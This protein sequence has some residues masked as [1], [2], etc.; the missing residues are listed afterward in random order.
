[1]DCSKVIFN[2]LGCVNCD[3]VLWIA[4]DVVEGWKL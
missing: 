2:V 3:K 1:V 4:V